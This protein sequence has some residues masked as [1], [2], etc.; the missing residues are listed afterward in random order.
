MR[1]VATLVLL[2]LTAP[3]T[4]QPYLY[5]AT[6][7]DD[8]IARS[9]LDGSEVDVTFIDGQNQPEDV[10]TDGA[11]LYWTNQLGNS[12]GRA[13]LDGSSVNPAFITGITTPRYLTLDGTY[14]Y[15][16]DPG[17]SAIG[18]AHLDGSG[19]NQE[20][21]GDIFAIGLDVT[22]SHIYWATGFDGTIARA[23][24]DGSGVDESF[25]A[26][27]PNAL[28][29]HVAGDF[30]FWTRQFGGGVGRV[31]LDGSN[32]TPDLIPEAIVGNGL[33]SDGS[34][35]YISHGAFSSTFIAT[36]NLDGSDYAVLL[37]YPGQRAVQ[38]LTVGRGMGTSNAPAAVPDAA[39][40]LSVTPNP[41]RANARLTVETEPGNDIRIAVYDAL[42]REVTVPFAGT[43]GAERTLT[44]A[45]DTA[46]L[47]AGLYVVRAESGDRVETTKLTI[48]R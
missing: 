6:G 2:L 13:N 33:S 28:E 46:G 21:I 39:L 14:L 3:V 47:P 4:A 31:D 35:L 5:W 8:S 12:I 7:T 1:L 20:F 27:A 19:V 48:V 29:V 11:Y 15:W 44:V 37:T 36:A 42:G 24:I 32:P 43:F 26:D 45:L 16:S 25:V 10:V 34:T 22:D 18:R 41:T 30:L 38:G 17:A 40:R 9:N 23:S